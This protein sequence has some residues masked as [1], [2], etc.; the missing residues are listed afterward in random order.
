[1]I[2]ELVVHLGDTKTGSTSIQKVLKQKAYKTAGEE[3]CYPTQNHHNALVRTLTRK[4]HLPQREVR[5]GS[6]YDRMSKSKAKLGVVSAEHF[7]F[8]NPE[9]FAQAARQYWPDLHENMRLIS[10]IRPHHEKLLSSYSE[11]VKLGIV[12]RDFNAFVEEIFES[13]LLDYAPRLQA[14]REV[15]GDRFVAKP[16][17]R[18]AFYKE[19]VVEDFFKYALGHENFSIDGTATSNTSLTL[20][21]L[22]LLRLA[23]QVLSKHRPTEDQK[24][25]PSLFEAR[26][27]FGRSISE[28]IN[29][30]G[31]GADGAKLRLPEE[32][33]ARAQKRYA[34]DAK[35]LD[36]QFFG[37]NSMSK[38]LENCGSKATKEVQSI[39]V[40]DY[41]NQETI[42][43]FSATTEI[44][45]K[46][47]V[48]N[49]R[50]FAKMVSATRL[51][52]E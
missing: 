49:P 8:A 46:M 4:R 28:H 43:A 25:N 30:Q 10:Y 31:L 40:E 24:K 47:L 39:A 29:A 23:H 50:R 22:S 35:K 32:F 33:V 26:S 1:M 20:P 48:K 52:F 41:F 16:F 6:V 19:D 5:F 13:K 3:I 15:F 7:Q 21:Q 34:K 18:S 38:A 17:V 2:K 9:L 14:W 27:S 51:M 44:M 37:G 45:A 42:S 36:D 11:R 12:S